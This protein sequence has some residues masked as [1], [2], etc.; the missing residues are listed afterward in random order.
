MKK[1]NSN[2]KLFWLRLQMFFFLPLDGT[3]NFFFSFNFKCKNW[4]S[5]HVPFKRQHNDTIYWC[6]HFSL[7][8]YFKLIIWKDFRKD[9]IHHLIPSLNDIKC[10]WKAI[11]TVNDFA[12]KKVFLPLNSDFRSH[13]LPSTS[14]TVATAICTHSECWIVHFYIV[15][16]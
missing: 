11:K 12:E 3:K 8:N 2:H 5:D 10:K 6:E 7:K 4:V 9:L 1:V 13:S 14:K 15:V 16:I